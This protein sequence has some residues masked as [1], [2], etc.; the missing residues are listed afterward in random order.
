[1]QD[2][3]I[4]A[5]EVSG[6]A[7]NLKISGSISELADFPELNIKDITDFSVD[8]GD[9]TYVNSAGVRRWVKWMWAIEKDRPQIKFYIQRCPARIVRQILAISSFV[10]KKTVVQS[11]FA[12]YFCENDSKSFAKLIVVEPW[13][14]KDFDALSKK[15]NELVKCE[16][17]GHLMSFDA[18][19]DDYYNLIQIPT[20]N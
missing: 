9:V 3:M 12:P 11:F 13:F 10:P 20:D 4:V 5:V 16:S 6:Q 17:C 14:Q 1:M 2:R 7:L 8:F 15:L 19:V 18:S